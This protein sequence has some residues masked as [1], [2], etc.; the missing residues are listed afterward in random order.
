MELPKMSATLSYS[1]SL[2]EEFKSIIFLFNANHL[3]NKLHVHFDDL[4]PVQNEY[5]S[6]EHYKK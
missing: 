3:L 1:E 5:D 6:W 2:I 4:D